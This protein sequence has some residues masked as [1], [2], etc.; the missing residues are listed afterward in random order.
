MQ[1]ISRA[2]KET[3]ITLSQAP[4][5]EIATGIPMADHLLAQFFYYFGK[6]YKLQVTG[7]LDID[8]HHTF[9]DLGY[10]LGR[11]IRLT[12]EATAVAR[13]G[14]VVQVMDEA[15]I[16]LA[17]DLSGRGYFVANGFD[18]I[19]LS[20]G[21]V[22]W[23]EISECLSAMCRES[24]LCLHVTKVTGTNGHHIIEALFKGLGR[25]LAL[26]LAPIR[27]QTGDLVQIVRSTKGKVI[28][29]VSE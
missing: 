9:E 4:T 15:C 17:V 16:T 10:V 21:E 12:A 7:D 28:W 18:G 2:S 8:C 13:F 6:A 5:L 24:G 3:Q 26:A 29:E 14:D 20:R 11:M 22:S 1:S 23:D 19:L 27:P 25:V